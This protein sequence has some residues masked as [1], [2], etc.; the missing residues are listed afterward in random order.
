[1]APRDYD[2][3]KEKAKRFF[4]EF[5]RDG[6]DGRK[7]FPYREQLTALAR[8]EQVA[9]WV[10]L[11]DVAE[12]EPELAE[13]VVENVRRYGRV[14]SD[15]VHELLPHFGSAEAAPRDPLDVYLEHRL[16][17]V[18]RGRATGAPQDPQNQ[19]PPELLRRFELYFRA[20]SCSKALSPRELR[21]ASIGA[22]VTVQ[23]I[24][25]RASEVRPLLRVAT[26]SCDQC[27]AETYQPVLG[28][29]GLPLLLCPSRECQTNRSGGRLYLQSRGSKFTKFQELR[30]QEHSDQVPVGHLP[31]SLSLHLCGAN[32]RQAQPGDHVRVTG[33]FLPL[34]RP[35][36]RQVT[37]GLLSE[38]FLEGHHL[39]KV[40]KSEEEE[41]EEGELSPEE[42]QQIMGTGEDFYGKLAASIA[43]EIF[44]HEDVKKSLLL[45][46]VGGVERSPRGMRIRGNINICLMGDPGV[47]KSQLLTYIDRLA[48]RS[49]YTTGRGS[50]AVG[51]GLTAAVL[52]DPQS[53]ELA[54]EGGALVLADR[55]V[56]CI[57]EFDKM[58][59]SDRVAVH[60][61]LEQQS[62][63]VAKAG[64]VA[65]L[66]ARC[67]V[68]A[69]ANTGLSGAYDPRRS[70]EH[71]LQLPAALLLS[72]FDLLWLLQDRPQRD[73]DLRLAQHIT[74][75]HQHCREPPSA[76]QPL[77]MKLMR[78][79][80][81]C[82]RRRAPACPEALGEFITAAYV[83][84]RRE[85]LISVSV[86]YTSART[87][88]AILR[89]ATAL[90]RLRLGALV[91]KD[92]VSEALRLLE[93]ARDS[94]RGEP[95]PGP[96]CPRPSE[97]ILGA[98]RELA[99]PG[100]RSLP[101][102]RALEALAARGFTPAQAAAALAEY[103]EL[104]VLHVNPGRTRLT[105]V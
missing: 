25:T 53:G 75:V 27:G 76:F 4:Q 100:G 1:M 24:V 60:E 91:E 51:V 6:A 93:A 105:F 88:L 42:L 17:L 44:G 10:A 55:S 85:S 80:L 13:A 45:L 23:G 89:L 12:D 18:Q 77:D 68:L 9:L 41:G 97:A 67:A 16:L 71:N 30:I 86:I 32:T 26:Y 40:N 39:A 69:A 31:R 104:N 52:R 34:L 5:Y 29:T 36:Y 58:A 92:D 11:D 83:E 19:F 7:E 94:L 21:A 102:P 81:C 101:L 15:A 54:L 63:A 33:T 95:E 78:R 46:L 62:V 66:N 64:V 2:S 28:H 72:R 61:A 59:D 96:R 14:F 74:Y 56:C 84:L 90:A 65:T 79:Y 50:S 99:G 38:T 22:L 87:L 47:A 8:R 103:E 82:C 70:L 73:R 3:E 35:G 98:L 37:Q 49:Q 20:P 43:P 57:D 48:P